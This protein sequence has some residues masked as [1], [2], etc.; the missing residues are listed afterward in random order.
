MRPG[1]FTHCNPPPQAL[2]IKVMRTMA[3]VAAV[4]LFFA[5]GCPMR[6]STTYV[7][8]DRSTREWKNEH[9]LLDVHTNPPGIPITVNGEYVG[10]SPLKW[11]M[12][13]RVAR[14]QG[15]LVE[16]SPTAEGQHGQATRI[17]CVGRNWIYPIKVFLDMRIERMQPKERIEVE[18]K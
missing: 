18:V 2:N 14:Q 8:Y 12:P 4:P 17:S 13:T 5:S 10:E 16:G 9:F 6:S 3:L 1:C 7:D 11:L 15:I